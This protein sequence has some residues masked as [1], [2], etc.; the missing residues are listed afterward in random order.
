MKIVTFTANPALDCYLKTEKL[1]AHRI[2]TG[3]TERLFPGGKGVNAARVLSRFGFQSGSLFLQGGENGRR[4]QGLLR[5]EGVPFSCYRIAGESRRNYVLEDGEGSRCKINTPGPVLPPE[6]DAGALVNWTLLHCRRGDVLL[7]AGSFPPGMPSDFC[8]RLASAAAAAGVSVALDA[9][10]S[11]FAQAEPSSILYG[12]MNLA[13]FSEFTGKPAGSAAEAAVPAAA[14]PAHQEILI[15]MGGEGTLLLAGG[16]RYF[17]RPREVFP[18]LSCGC[19]DV[20]FACYIMKRCEGLD[21]ADALCFA[22]SCAASC[23]FSPLFGLI[24]PA[25][26]RCG[27]EIEEMGERE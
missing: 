22:V 6:F 16:R 12:K 17:C 20:L 21:A 14:F 1:Q 27:V 8:G 26:R 13:E 3:E 2:C 15:S 4:I 9:A 24:Y 5:S 25:D 11:L 19:G 7:I 18:H 23:A 10:G